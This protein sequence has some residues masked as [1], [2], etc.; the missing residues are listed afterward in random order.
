MHIIKTTDTLFKRIQFFKNKQKIL[1]LVPTMGNLHEGH[2]KLILLAQKYVD[3]IIVS[4]FINPMQF[5]NELDFKKYPKTFYKDCEILKKLKIDILFAPKISEMYPNGA[6]MNTYIQVPK[7]SEI[8]EGKSRPGHFTGVTTI[9]GKLFNLIQPNFSF[10]GEKDY[11]QLL[12]IKTFVKEL[13]YSVKIISLP[14]VRLKNGLA[15][16]SR[17][18]NLKNQELQ[19]APFLYQVIKQTINK[20]IQNNGKNLHKIINFSKISLIKKGF[21]IDIFDVYNAK[22]LDNFS[23]EQKKNILLAS[24]WL[25]KTRLIDNKKFIL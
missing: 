19:K 18:R 2:I 13:N 23:K 12:I 3:I 11:Q 1:G 17:N 5:N 10:F 24:V 6:K 15:F 22:T 9:V 20:I 25:G 4:L 16:S 8:I 7:L 21:L 14:T